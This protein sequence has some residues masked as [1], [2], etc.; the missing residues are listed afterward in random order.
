[1]LAFNMKSEKIIIAV[2]VCCILSE[3]CGGVHLISMF[4]VLQRMVII[5]QISDGYQA[6]LIAKKNIRRGTQCCASCNANL[7][8]ET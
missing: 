6:G 7:T 5:H 4:D 8:M 3:W 2:C 1:M